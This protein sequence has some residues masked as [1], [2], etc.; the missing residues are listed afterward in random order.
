MKWSFIFFLCAISLFSHST[1]EESLRELNELDQSV[2]DFDF[3]QD[4][5]PT[6]EQ[7]LMEALKLLESSIDSTDSLD[8]PHESI[9]DPIEELTA[10]QESLDSQLLESMEDEME[11]N[12]EQGLE[13]DIFELLE[14]DFEEPEDFE[15]T[16]EF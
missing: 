8:T 4:E 6:D 2:I 12:I 3:Y 16:D 13:D 1:E 10:E 11:S 14:D 5:T 15:E 9:T 7:N